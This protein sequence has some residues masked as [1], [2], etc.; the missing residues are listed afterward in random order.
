M[1]L[2]F[3]IFNIIFYPL[4]VY[5]IINLWFVTDR[6]QEL[7]LTHR[8]RDLYF[9]FIVC[10]IIMLVFLTR[11]KNI[12]LKNIFLLFNIIF[13]LICTLYYD[14]ILVSTNNYYFEIMNGVYAIWWIIC[15]IGYLV[16][17]VHCFVMNGHS[18]MTCRNNKKKV[19]VT[20]NQF[21]GTNSLSHNP[22]T[23]Y[24]F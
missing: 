1:N 24:E 8:Q 5:N 21:N 4:I 3:H 12:I 16:Y 17:L 6:Y 11:N 19:T 15:V 13:G 14:I 18:V 22:F 9:G 7:E 23:A 10:Q 20:N 2:T